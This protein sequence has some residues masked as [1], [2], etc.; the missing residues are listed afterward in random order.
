M[1]RLDSMR[2]TR[3]YIDTDWRL[4]QN[5]Q[6]SFCRFNPRQPHVEALVRNAK[7]LV[8][9]TQY[10]ENSC[11][12]ITDVDH[13]LLGMITKWICRTVGDARFDPPPRHPNPPKCCASGPAVAG[14]AAC[15]AGL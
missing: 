7:S 2:P 8:I 6:H 13:I 9:N 1:Q 4:R 10:M 14:S 12:Q 5:R 15:N 3:Q 11:M